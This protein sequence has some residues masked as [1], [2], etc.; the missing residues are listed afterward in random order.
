MKLRAFLRLT[1]QNRRLLLQAITALATCDI[2]LRFQGMQRLHAWATK[3]RTARITAE[4]SDLI[5]AV[6][7]ASRR[8]P[9]STCLKR[10]LALQRLLSHHGHYSELRIGVE[11]SDDRFRAHAWLM[12][13]DQVVMGSPEFRE[14]ELLTAWQVK[15]LQL[16][17]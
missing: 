6:Q 5:W 3:Q 4:P 11:K 9:R 17:R 7:V 10:A 13:D 12:C 14:Y 2:R 15:G 8:L 16:R 1:P